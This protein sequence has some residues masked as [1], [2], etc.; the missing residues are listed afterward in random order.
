M[1]KGFERMRGDD[2]L[3]KMGHGKKRKERGHRI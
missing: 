2:T 3:R 1:K